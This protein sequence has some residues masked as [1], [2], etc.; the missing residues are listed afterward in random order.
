M[1]SARSLSYVVT[2]ALSGALHY[3]Y[4]TVTLPLQVRYPERYITVTLPLQVRYPE[5][6]FPP[7]A[8]QLYSYIKHC[9]M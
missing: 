3:R 4:I 2:G 6:W 8:Q 7:I 9:C 1:M 5:R